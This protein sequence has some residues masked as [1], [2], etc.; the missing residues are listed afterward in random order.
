[1]PAA[2][3]SFASESVKYSSLSSSLQNDS[4]IIVLYFPDILDRDPFWP[5]PLLYD[6]CDQQI[7]IN[8]LIL[9]SLNNKK[10]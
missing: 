2:I 3:A 9:C 6:I 8:F 4:A 5:N 10:C 7:N 1:M